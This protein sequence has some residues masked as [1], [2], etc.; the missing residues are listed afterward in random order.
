VP[1][2]QRLD[3]V[4]DDGLD[5]QEERRGPQQ[6]RPSRVDRRRKRQRKHGRDDSADIGHEAQNGGEDPPQDG[7]GNSDNPQTH[8]DHEAERS[9][10]GEL[11]QKQPT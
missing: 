6:H 4:A 5:D 11:H 9:V 10:H 3:D 8:A 7:T 2:E 1:I